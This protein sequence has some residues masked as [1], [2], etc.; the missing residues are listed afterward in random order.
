MARTL[1]GECRDRGVKVWEN[2][3]PLTERSVDDFVRSVETAEIEEGSSLELRCWQWSIS[4]VDISLRIGT[5]DGLV[6]LQTWKHTLKILDQDVLP[7]EIKL[8]D[9]RWR[10]LFC[11][12]DCWIPEKLLHGPWTDSKL[13]FLEIL[14]RAGARVDWIGSTAGE[15]ASKGLH[16]AI[17]ECNVRAVKALVTIPPRIYDVEKRNNVDKWALREE[18]DVNNRALLPREEANVYAGVTPRTEHLRRAVLGGCHK[19]IVRRLLSV[20]GEVDREDREVVGWGLRKRE[21]GDARGKWLL[22]AL[23]VDTCYGG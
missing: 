8:G 9:W 11:V 6:R 4:N 22:D 2:G 1:L 7:W 18:G 23:R 15:T 10:L 3:S 16:D 5:R 14:A 20:P 13:T 17:A 19:D 12:D 21:E